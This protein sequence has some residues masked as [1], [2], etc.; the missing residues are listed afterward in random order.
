WSSPFVFTLTDRSVRNIVA[1]CES[2]KQEREMGRKKNYDRDDL[3]GKA[4]EVFRDHGFE[5][6]T[7]QML[8]ESLGVNKFSI[9]S[10]F[11]SKQK[12]FEEALDRYNREVVD[13]NFGPLEAPTAGVKEIRELLMFFASASNGSA[14]GRGCLLCNTAVEFGPVDP[15]G[16]EFVQRYFGHISKAFYKALNTSCNRGELDKSIALKGEAD[17]FTSLTLGL[18]VMIRAKAP[19]E[20]IENAVKV[21]IEHLEGLQGKG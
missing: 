21:A 5:G 14:S 20:I 4:M 12:L 19:L 7:T 18:F 15:T 6:T 8:V 17:F 10:E 16:G 13:R 9:Y 11:G 3:T 1:E 2:V